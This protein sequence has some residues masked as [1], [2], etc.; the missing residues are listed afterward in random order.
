MAWIALKNEIGLQ[1][2]VFS[3]I[4]PGCLSITAKLAVVKERKDGRWSW[5][6]KE[7]GVY[8]TKNR[9]GVAQDFSSAKATVLKHIEEDLGECAMHGEYS[10]YWGE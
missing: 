1:R 8:K 10:E 7:G 6:V 4:I 9:Q 2:S 5:Y 3:K